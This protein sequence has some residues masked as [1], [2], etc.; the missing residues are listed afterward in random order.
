[1]SFTATS[2][3]HQHTTCPA[4]SRISGS[5]QRA[6]EGMNTTNAANSVTPPVT[7]SIFSANTRQV[8]CPPLI[9]LLCPTGQFLGGGT[10][11]ELNG[12]RSG[13]HVVPAPGHA[14][15]HG[16][17]PHRGLSRH[18]ADGLSRTHRPAHPS[19]PYCTKQPPWL[20]FDTV[21]TIMG[22]LRTH[23]L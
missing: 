16:V 10:G 20:N 14:E 9:A 12:Q 21:K 19:P 8:V 5:L 13:V 4:S 23:P 6:L 18:R 7:S 3:S 11:L 1:M 22:F 17:Q 15:Q 2:F